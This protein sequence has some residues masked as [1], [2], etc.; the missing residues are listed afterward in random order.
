MR[1]AISI[2]NVITAKF[3]TLPFTGIWKD[4]VGEP[5]LTGSWIIYGPPKNGKTSFAMMLSKY[6]TKH[7]NRVAYNSVEEGLSLTIQKAMERVNMLEVAKKVLLYDKLDIDDLIEKLDKHKSPDVVIIDS[8]QFLEM[9]FKDY[10]TL[11][12]R[13]PNKLFIYI[14]HID[15]KEPEGRVAKRI[16][17]DANVIFRIEGYRAFPTSRYESEGKY[18]DIYSEGANQYWGIEQLDQ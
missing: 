14:S 3:E 4:A 17:R 6:I 11:K 7:V 16:W 5:E 13:Y 18:I 1:N 12:Q 8:V 15:G 9:T 10:K 2:N